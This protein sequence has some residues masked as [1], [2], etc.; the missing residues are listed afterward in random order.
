M[1]RLNLIRPEARRSRRRLRTC[2]P[3]RGACMV[4]SGAEPGERGDDERLRPAVARRLNHRREGRR[5]IDRY[6]LGYPT[7]RFASAVEIRLDAADAPGGV[8]RLQWHGEVAE[9]LTRRSSCLAMSCRIDPKRLLPCGGR[10]VRV[11][12]VVDA[13]TGC[14]CSRRSS[15]RARSLGGRHGDAPGAVRLRADATTVR[16]T[17]AQGWAV[18]L[19]PAFTA[20]P[21]AGNRLTSSRRPTVRRGRVH[22]WLGTA[23]P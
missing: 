1:F 13:P 23:R 3:R 18:S 14:K 12:R 19:A 9:V 21:P 7:A 6:V 4:R 5:M 16:L 2:P 8:R 11:H 20:V 15:R 17:P 10:R 22:P